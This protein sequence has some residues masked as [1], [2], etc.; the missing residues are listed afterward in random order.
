MSGYKYKGNSM[1]E[2]VDFKNFKFEVG[3]AI[4]IQTQRSI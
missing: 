2:S 3:D 4:F 1:S